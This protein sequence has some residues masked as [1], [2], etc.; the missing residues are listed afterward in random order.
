MTKIIMAAGATG[1]HIMPAVAVALA[2]KEQEPQLKVLFVGVGRKAEADIL[3]PILG[4]LGWERVT[5]KAGGVKGRGILGKI[6]GLLLTVMGFF[7][8]IGVLKKFKPDAVFGA[9]GYAAGPVG[10]AAWALGVPLFIHEQNRTPGVTN[11]LLASLAQIV[12][13]GDPEGAKYFKATKV[14]IV[15]NPV[16]Q[17]ILNVVRKAE[18]I[19][20]LLVLGGSQG[21]R[22]INE[23]VLGL[24]DN[25]D[26]LKAPIKIIHQAGASGVTLLEEAYRKAKQ[27]T[28]L[29]YELSAFFTDMARVY[30]LG[31]LALCRAGALTLAELAA[32]GMASILVPL[33]T[34][35]DDHQSQNALSFEKKGAA[36]VIPEK[37][38]TGERLRVEI[39]RL[40]EDG[41]LLEEMGTKAGELKKTDAA[42][43]MASVILEEIVKSTNAFGLELNPNGTLGEV[44]E[45]A[46]RP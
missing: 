9:G 16:R 45:K 2:L 4:P 18:S 1:G 5:I 26:K 12:F 44:V 17:E 40:M 23:A 29:D 35:A 33:P 31:D 39:E 3:D 27:E 42:S 20:T 34:A 22:G 36:I 37:E 8:A 21:A 32:V 30:S 10:L 46:E 28:G 13:L 25:L 19:F 38:L 43:S 11:K 24:L 41:A 15:G 6:K 7:S 14:R